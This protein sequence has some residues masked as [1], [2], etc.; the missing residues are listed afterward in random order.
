MSITDETLMAYVDGELSESER[1]KVDSAVAADPALQERLEKHRRFRARMGGVFANVLTEPLPE[2]LVEAARPS[3]VVPFP[4]RRRAVPA[5]AAIA[6]TLV[7]GV[8]AGMSVSRGPQPIVGSDFRAH[9]AL[10]TALDKQLA[11]APS[12]SA[13]RIGLTFRTQDTYCR[14]FTAPDI[15]G[16]ACR[17][18]NHWKVRLATARQAGAATEYRTAASETPPEVLDA[19]QAL[20][21]GLPLDASAEAKAVRSRWRNGDPLP[22]R[23]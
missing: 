1:L 9:G 6:A 16:L 11:S 19:A 4:T 23:P 18:N 20:M 14:T 21:I 10:A 15:A 8:V 7:V 13:V 17:E 12:D 3:N 2:R 22:A 5:W